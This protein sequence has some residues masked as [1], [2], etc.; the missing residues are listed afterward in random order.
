MKHRM[1]LSC[2]KPRDILA[3]YLTHTSTIYVLRVSQG[4]LRWQHIRCHGS[5]I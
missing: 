3:S 5:N 2:I 4:K 1:N